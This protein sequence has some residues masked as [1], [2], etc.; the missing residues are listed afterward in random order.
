MGGV[1][2]YSKT[3][4]KR[5]ISKRPQIGFRDILS[6]NAGQKYCRM[7]QGEYSAILMTIK[8]PFVI[9]KIFLLSTFEW[10]FYTYFTCILH[11]YYM[12]FKW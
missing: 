12:Y 4:V 9:I 3:S 5:P 1:V 7:L 11:V 8:I 6:L 2:N 10:P